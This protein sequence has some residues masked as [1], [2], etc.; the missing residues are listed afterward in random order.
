MPCIPPH[1]EPLF[2]FLEAFEWV[3]MPKVEEAMSNVTELKVSEILDFINWIEYHNDCITRFGFPDRESLTQ[4]YNTKVTDVLFLRGIHIFCCYV[5][6][7][8]VRTSGDALCM[9]MVGHEC[10]VNTTVTAS[11]KC[12]K[13]NPDC[14]VSFVYVHIVHSI[15]YAGGTHVRVQG[16][17]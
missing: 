2:V 13:H 3:L 14:N 6:E 10:T 4:L 1:Y 15:I 17:H 16:S 11:S 5:R 8:T 9:T 7:T 12:G